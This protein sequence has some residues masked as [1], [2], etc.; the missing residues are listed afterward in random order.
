M[1]IVPY[2]DFERSPM[3]D[4]AA[5]GLWKQQINLKIVRAPWRLLPRRMDKL[6]KVYIAHDL[7]L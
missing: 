7:R 3:L 1:N 2:I 6:P 5:L 4:F